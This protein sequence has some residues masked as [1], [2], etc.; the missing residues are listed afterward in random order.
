MRDDNSLDLVDALNSAI[1][2]NRAEIILSQSDVVR[3]TKLDVRE[4]EGLAALLF[5]RSDPNAAVPIFEHAK[6][7][8][9]RKSDKSSDE[10]VAVSSHLFIN[11]REIKGQHNSTHRAIIEEMPGIGRTYMQNIINIVLRDTPYMYEHRGGDDKETYSI[12]TVDGIK[13]ETIADSLKDS[14]IQH[15]TLTRPGKLTG[16]DTE[17]LVSPVDETLRLIIRAKHGRVVE[18]LERI[19]TWMRIN[20]WTNMLVRVDMPDHRSRNVSIEREAGA[21]EALFV[22]AD[23]IDVTTALDVCSD[24]I[25]DELCARAKE[26]FARR[27]GW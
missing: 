4:Q 13:S 3:L 11:L 24:V 5:R 10:A 23:P 7:R 16:M 22:R 18:F 21:A 27:T 6:T 20:G 9:L 1:K 14:A 25:S 15:V 12:V 17:G 8:K 19:K 2:A 26:F